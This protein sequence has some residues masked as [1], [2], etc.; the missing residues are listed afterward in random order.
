[1][2][3]QQNNP[4]GDRQAQAN[5]PRENVQSARGQKKEFL[6]PVVSVPIDV[7]EV[8]SLFMLQTTLG[9]TVTN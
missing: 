2:N 5:E 8:T 6:E 3:K 4:A 1:L 9:G 7:M